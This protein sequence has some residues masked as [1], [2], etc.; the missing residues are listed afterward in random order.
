[1]HMLIDMKKT[2]CD[3]SNRILIYN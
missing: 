3:L 1:M 2:K